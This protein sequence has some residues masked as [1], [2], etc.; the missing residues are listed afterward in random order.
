MKA[1]VRVDGVN[2]MNDLLGYIRYLG[3]RSD[4]SGKWVGV[5]L[6][7]PEGD[8]DGQIGTHRYFQCGPLRGKFLRPRAVRLEPAGQELGPI[9]TPCVDTHRARSRSGSR[10]TTPGRGSNG[11]ARTQRGSADIFERRARS[12]TRGTVSSIDPAAV[13]PSPFSTSLRG[14][15]RSRSRER[16]K[17]VSRGGGAWALEAEAQ[18]SL[19][20]GLSLTEIAGLSRSK[21]IDTAAQFQGQALALKAQVTELEACVSRLRGLLAEREWQ[22]QFFAP[23]PGYRVSRC[24]LEPIVPPA[25]P[26][27]P[28]NPIPSS[29]VSP[30][31]SAVFREYSVRPPTTHLTVGSAGS[32]L[33]AR[34]QSIPAGNG[35]SQANTHASEIRLL[36]K[37]EKQGEKEGEG[38]RN[39]RED[40]SLAI[41]H[42]P[43]ANGTLLRK[44]VQLGG[45]D[46][47]S[48]VIA[49]P[50][51]NHTMASV[52]PAVVF[53]TISA[54]PSAPQH[55][56]P[57]LVARLREE[58]ARI[59]NE[60]F[61]REVCHF[62]AHALPE[63]LSL[64]EFRLC[65]RK[66]D[67]VKADDAALFSPLG[68]PPPTHTSVFSPRISLSDS[69]LAAVF[70]ELD[71]YKVGS[72]AVDHLLAVLRRRPLHLEPQN[73]ASNSKNSNKSP[74]GRHSNES[75]IVAGVPERLGERRR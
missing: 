70:D 62:Y 32:T 6:D 34:G 48:I 72:I 42:A 1:R 46:T 25:D 28:N 71:S 36:L 56:V 19:D 8:S 74:E 44:G 27:N 9:A 49:A 23:P 17:S 12:R 5:E 67:T 64:H 68:R 61:W 69:E 4:K 22:E 31:P 52:D 15:E 75:R 47:P 39:G 26:N 11:S 24:V 37:N 41:P 14:R 38:E 43:P 63:R 50:A 73:P 53:S 66:W 30:S 65:M 59:G 58:A 29:T 51:H 40:E 45:P 16:S 7:A 35:Q 33:P 54:L 13:N 60:N 21:L 57:A 3:E 55:N 10:S 18:T 2:G 20:G